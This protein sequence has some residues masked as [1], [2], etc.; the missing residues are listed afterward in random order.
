MDFNR[1]IL[2][3]LGNYFDFFTLE[4]FTST[5]FKPTHPRQKTTY[6]YL[7]LAINLVLSLIPQVPYFNALY[8]SFCFLYML[9]ISSFRFKKALVFFVKY[10]IVLNV[11]QFA[12]GLF[13]ALVNFDMYGAEYIGS[14]DV[15]YDYQWI[16][17]IIFAY[18]LLNLYIN[19]KN[20]RSLRIKTIYP[21]VYSLLSTALILILLLFN[22]ML[23]RYDALTNLLPWIYLSAVG[24]IVLSLN[25]YRNII[26]ILEEQT[27][28][29]LLVE[30]YE[31]ELSYFNDV[32][33][34]LDTLS[35]LRH[36]FKNHLIV[37]DSYAEQNKITELRDYIS[38]VSSF[39]NTSKLI[40]TENDLVSSILNT[41][42]AACEKKGISF[43]ANCNFA[44]IH[45]SDFAIITILGNILDNAITA[46]S[47]TEHGEVAF[48]LNEL[49]GYL[50]ISC[51]NNHDGNIKEKN[52][53]FT[54]TK[55]DTGGLHGLGISNVR[56]CVESLRGTTDISYD[57]RTF[58]VTILLPN[59]VSHR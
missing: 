12:S 22:N 51:Q 34:S 41:K 44:H 54:S 25:S 55:A 58:S 35:R 5:F 27:K 2:D 59:H 33:N 20:L 37:L 56:D 23:A 32:Q 57:D 11:L 40:S 43:S 28:Q 42:N 24:I 10:Q 18:V 7:F 6:R 15:F 47:K 13:G 26:E 1:F 30:K 49:N 16:T 52:G 8:Y 48:S 14:D 4:L 36:D 45:I 50:E 38:K 17:A 53:E 29:K 19:T 3:L 46:A 39:L 21:R 31:M 9:L